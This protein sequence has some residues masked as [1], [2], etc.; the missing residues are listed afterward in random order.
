MSIPNRYGS[1]RLTHVPFGTAD[2]PPDKE[3]HIKGAIS[4]FQDSVLGNFQHVGALFG[5]FQPN[6]TQ[7]ENERKPITGPKTCLSAK[8]LNKYSNDKLCFLTA[9][10]KKQRKDEEKQ[11]KSIFT[12]KILKVCVFLVY[13]IIKSISFYNSDG[14]KV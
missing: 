12:Y 1:T 3:N 14:H 11:N 5:H 8:N 4:K 9:P 6:H 13:Q 7:V 2:N 10:P